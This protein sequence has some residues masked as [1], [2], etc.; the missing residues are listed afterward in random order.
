MGEYGTPDCD[1]PEGE[2]PGECMRFP[3]TTPPD[4]CP[5][6]GLPF[7]KS[8]GSF[9]HLS[10]VHDTNNIIFACKTW[11]L[12][13][14]DIMQG[15]VFGLTN[16]APELLTRF[17]YD[18][19]FGTCINRFCAQALIN[20]PLTVYGKGNQTRGYLPL[21]DSIQCLTIAINNPPKKGEYRVFNQYESTYSINELANLVAR[22]SKLLG[23]P[24]GINHI[25]N[26][27]TEK[28]NHYY[29]P[30]HDKLSR[31]G[32]TPDKDIQYNIT[33]TLKTLIP[34]KGR[35]IKKVIRPKTTW[36]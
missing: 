12:T 5:M 6:R 26:P 19:Y 34:Y 23:F 18:E 30:T 16:T 24:V 29:N 2:I 32:Y 3:D 21:K 14:T 10:K 17:D 1:I 35:I 36:R 20:Y 11:G 8:P 4:E 33:E 28:E 7:P 31:L 9:Y 22:I 27:R 25:P 13:S 15:V